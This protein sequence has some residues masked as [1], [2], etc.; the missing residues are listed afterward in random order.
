ML[1]A[2]MLPDPITAFEYATGD[3]V[4]LILDTG[5]PRHALRTPAHCA[6]GTAPTGGTRRRAQIRAW[7]QALHT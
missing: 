4:G 2:L 3:H 6:D 5:R 7:W 1:G